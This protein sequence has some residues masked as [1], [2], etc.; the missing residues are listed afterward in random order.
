MFKAKNVRGLL[1]GGRMLVFCDVLRS[2]DR[3]SCVATF[4]LERRCF[5]KAGF[6]GPGTAAMAA[7]GVAGAALSL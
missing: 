2:S 4:A 6:G 3:G 5:K 1:H 7:E